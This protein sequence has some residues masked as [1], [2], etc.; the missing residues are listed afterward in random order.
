[1]LKSLGRS[2]LLEAD[3]L[4]RGLEGKRGGAP[5]GDVNK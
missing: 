3:N 5:G 1:M 2:S 4:P